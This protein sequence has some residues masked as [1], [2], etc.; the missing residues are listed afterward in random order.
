MAQ[1]FRLVKYD[2]LPRSCINGS[3][4]PWKTI[5]SPEGINHYSMNSPLIF[6]SFPIISTA[7]NGIY[8]YST[9]IWSIEFLYW[10]KLVYSSIPR[11]FPENSSYQL[12]N[13]PLICPSFTPVNGNIPLTAMVMTVHVQGG[14][15]CFLS[16]I[17][18]AADMTWI[19]EKGS[20]FELPH[21]M[22]CFF[23]NE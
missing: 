14:F 3:S 10:R 19:C 20:K 5:R 1:Q 2:H 4:I 23:P 11:I 6:Q 16:P 15:M 17:D 8:D 12:V 18:L 22:L 9:N 7:F 21:W 13:I